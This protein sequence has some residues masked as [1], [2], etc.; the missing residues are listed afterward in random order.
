MYE[1]DTIEK[2]IDDSQ[3]RNIT[4][5]NEM[6]ESRLSLGI[7]MTISAFFGIWG[8]TCLISGLGQSAS[9][10]EIGSTLFTA[11]TGM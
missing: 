11:L 4:S 5:I 2:V 1:S 6:G 7:I 8:V 10:Q 9:V 3:E